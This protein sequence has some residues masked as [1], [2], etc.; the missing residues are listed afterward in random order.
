MSDTREFLTR[1]R[2][3]AEHT[4]HSRLAEQLGVER[5]LLRNWLYR[6][7]PSKWAVSSLSKKVNALWNRRKYRRNGSQS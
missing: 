4:P 3:L 2:E 6:D 5:Y 1:L 7:R